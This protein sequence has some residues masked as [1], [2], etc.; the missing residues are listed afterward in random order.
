MNL[1]LVL[2][3]LLLLNM[4]QHS[5]SQPKVSEFWKRIGVEV[6]N[7]HGNSLLWQYDLSHVNLVIHTVIQARRFPLLPIMSGSLTNIQ[8]RLDHQ[9]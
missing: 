9:N 7:N 5:H 6:T 2:R 8:S 1:I 3:P 4:L